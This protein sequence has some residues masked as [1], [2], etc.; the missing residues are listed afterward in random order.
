MGRAVACN[1]QWEAGVP[2]FVSPPSV[3]LDGAG[4]RMLGVYGAFTPR[5]ANATRVA[6]SKLGASIVIV[7]RRLYSVTSPP[8][9]PS[10]A[11]GTPRSR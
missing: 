11:E 9:A 5:S 3:R 4:S 2:H 8:L 1:P 6:S 10:V 7:V